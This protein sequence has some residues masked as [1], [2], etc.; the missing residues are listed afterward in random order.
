MI[1][2]VVSKDLDLLDLDIPDDWEI[3]TEDIS[4]EICGGILEG[5]LE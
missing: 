4:L 2:L 5:T 1:T 3:K